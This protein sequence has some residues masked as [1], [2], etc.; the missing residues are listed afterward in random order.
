MYYH[1]MKTQNTAV[2]QMYMQY[3][4]DLLK[5]YNMVIESSNSPSIHSLINTLKSIE[6]THKEDVLK[7]RSVDKINIDICFKDV[8]SLTPTEELVMLNKTYTEIKKTRKQIF[9][10]HFDNMKNNPKIF[11]QTS[12]NLIDNIS[13]VEEEFHTELDS[14][15]PKVISPKD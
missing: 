9:N 10:D 7:K 3:K 11:S 6:H 5:H 12:N 15:Q 2:M 14:R 13:K 4:N 8:L 1:K